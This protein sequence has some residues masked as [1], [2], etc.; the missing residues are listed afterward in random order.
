LRQSLLD[1]LLLVDR[2]PLSLVFIPASTEPICQAASHKF[3]QPNL[4][5]L[6]PTTQPARILTDTFRWTGAAN[7]YN[8]GFEDASLINRIG[9][10]RF[11]SD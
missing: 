8:L 7:T 1:A 6:R 9:S 5:T 2:W 11:I 3:D 4:Q 10:R